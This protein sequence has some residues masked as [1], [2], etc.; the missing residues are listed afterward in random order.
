MVIG[1]FDLSDKLEDIFYGGRASMGGIVDTDFVDG[2]MKPP[3][4]A[5]PFTV[6]ELK[7]VHERLRNRSLDHM[8][9]AIFL[10]DDV[11]TNNGMTRPMVEYLKAHW[12]QVL[13]LTDTGLE[14]PDTLYEQRQPVLSPEHYMLS[15]DTKNA[16]MGTLDE[17]GLF[18]SNQMVA[19]RFRISA[20]PLFNV[21]DG[22]IYN[23]NLRSPSLVRVQAYSAVAYGMRGLYYYCWGNGIWNLETPD[24]FSGPGSPSSIYDVVRRSNADL[25]I[26][27]Q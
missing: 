15:G 21:G 8:V 16:T 2:P 10:H 1:F 14:G 17:L 23:P 11:V 7:W 22:G 26:W 5:E 20:W 19:E 24:Q 9:H 18:A 6:P 25:K 27:G 3:H 12:P 13:P 4:R